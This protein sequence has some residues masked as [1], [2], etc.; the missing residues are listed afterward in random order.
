[1]QHLAKQKL[2]IQKPNGNCS[3]V[4]VQI[5][6]ATLPNNQMN[7]KATNLPGVAEF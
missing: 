4:T 6:I 5:A 3:R 2:E 1:M 7:E